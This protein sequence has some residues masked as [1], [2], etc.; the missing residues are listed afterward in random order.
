MGI[1]FHIF[2]HF[3]RVKTGHFQVSRDR[4]L[5]QWKFEL[6]GLS[7]EYG[8][9]YPSGTYFYS[10]FKNQVNFRCFTTIPFALTLDR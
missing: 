10:F 1:N 4:A 3:S 7:T 9:G 5:K 8:S 2:F 6:E